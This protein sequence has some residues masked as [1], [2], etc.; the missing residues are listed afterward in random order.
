[1][2]HKPLIP[3]VAA[4]LLCVALALWPAGNRLYFTAIYAGLS[5]CALVALVSVGKQWRW[6]AVVTLLFG[7]TGV[8]IGWHSHPPSR[9]VTN[10]NLR[11]LAGAPVW[12]Q[13]SSTRGGNDHWYA[14][15][16]SATDWDTAEKLAVSWGGTLATI[17]SAQEQY[18]I[19]N[20]FLT[21]DFE[22]LPLWIGL[23]RTSTNVPSSGAS[24][25]GY[26]V[27]PAAP[28][29]SGSSAGAYRLVPIGASGA[30][31]TFLDR[32][33]LAL[34][35]LGLNVNA[36]APARPKPEFSWVTGEDF[37]Y[38]NWKEGEPNNSPPGESW[39]AINWEYSDDPSRGNKG[40]W[41]DTPLNGTTHYGGN[42]S[43]P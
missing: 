36:G 16:P 4:S 2:K 32:V 21:G 37:D 19:N 24:T 3:A 8:Y 26:V 30:P 17:T 33:R 28:F 11:K 5:A 35:D 22:Y 23:V 31:L 25:G 9:P 14:R 6:F 43:G 41:N 18:F 38:S 39:V 13:W 42:T 10:P 34:S 7:L 27:V 12:I 20:T 40:D 15:T 1:M 29:P